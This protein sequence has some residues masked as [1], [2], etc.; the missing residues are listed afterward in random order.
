MSFDP[1]DPR[2]SNIEVLRLISPGTHP[3]LEQ[4]DAHSHIREV[5]NGLYADPPAD[6]TCSVALNDDGFD[7]ATGTSGQKTIAV[8]SPLTDTHS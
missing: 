7:T 3:T 2:N 5:A 8:P 1:V 4:M 6:G